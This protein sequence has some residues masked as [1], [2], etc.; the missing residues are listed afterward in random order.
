M[1][2]I[3]KKKKWSKGKVKDKAN[4][5]VT[6]DKATYDKIYKEVPTYRLITP[7]VVVDRMRISG[8]L[9]RVAL[10][11]LE[12]KGL[13]KLVTAHASQLIYTRATITTEA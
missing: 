12:S 1:A 5:A 2:N 10:R 13:I 11:E 4:N 8:S 3:A 7:S 6:L 9:A